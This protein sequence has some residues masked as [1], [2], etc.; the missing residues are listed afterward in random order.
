MSFDYA[1]SAVT[2][3]RLIKK[4]GQAVRIRRITVGAY[5]PALGEA[6]MTKLDHDGIGALLDFEQR[7]IDGSRIKVGDQ[8]L[9]LSPKKADGS[10]M[11]LPTTDDL[12]VIGTTE[13][14]VQPSKQL[15]PAGVPVLF[16]LHIRG[17]SANNV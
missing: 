17:T 14:S 15:A 8:R 6:P 13:Y 10:A 2:A 16:D 11:P 4:F 9:L 12:V 5:D 3:D 1:K 7:D